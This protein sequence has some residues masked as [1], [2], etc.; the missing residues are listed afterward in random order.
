MLNDEIRMCRE[1]RI[2]TI[3]L[4]EVCLK[5]ISIKKYFWNFP[6]ETVSLKIYSNDEESNKKQQQQQ[7]YKNLWQP[8]KVY[9]FKLHCG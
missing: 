4:Q 6:L 5:L 3:E 7:N 9:N 1:S 2:L 8:E